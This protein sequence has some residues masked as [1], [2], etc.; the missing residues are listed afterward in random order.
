MSLSYSIDHIPTST[1]TDFAVPA[2][3]GDAYLA[4]LSPLPLPKGESETRYAITTGDTSSPAVLVYRSGDFERKTG[5][6]KR[7]GGGLATFAREIDSVS[8]LSRK[9]PISVNTTI[10]V[11]MDFQVEAADLAYLFLAH[12][13]QFAPDGDQTVAGLTAYFSR[14]LFGVTKLK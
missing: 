2:P 11:P 1:I 14:L 13:V 7:I 12:V 10:N 5:L 8:G 9:A 6:I 3:I 4:A